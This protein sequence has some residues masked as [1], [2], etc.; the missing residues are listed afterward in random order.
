MMTSAQLDTPVCWPRVSA[1]QL[2]VFLSETERAGL[3]ACDIFQ[4]LELGHAEA[5]YKSGIG[6]ISLSDFFRIEG[7]IAR[8]LDDLTA[9]LSE[10]KLSFETGAFVTSQINRAATLNE[11][12]HSLATYFNMMHA[13]HYNVVRETDRTVTLII[14]D[15]TFPYTLRDD[16]EMVH[17]IG[18]CVL[19]KVQCLL[20]SLS[21]GLAQ[22]ALKR[23]S[24]KRRHRVPSDTTVSADHLCFW[25]APLSYRNDNY[26]L[27]FDRADAERTM[28][29]HNRV[30]LSAEGVFSR[31]VSYLEHRSPCSE[32]SCRIRVLELV[33]QGVYHQES[34]AEFLNMSVATLRRRLDA[35]GTSFREIVTAY[36]MEQATALLKK[37]YT[38]VRVT[39][40]LEY[41]DIRAFNRAFKRWTG[42]TPAAF[43]KR[44]ASVVAAQ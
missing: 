7:E 42:E 26:E 18:E 39:E 14:N 23:V 10:R 35:D 22:K 36:R 6:A 4:A 37:G 3:P 13:E 19:I 8:R 21:G 44:N 12:I 40:Q 30:D 1:R 31:V 11:A 29:K 32:T 2:K 24:L 27:V 43:A 41:S 25:T 38:V 9:H 20:D 5:V 16:P 17:F 28:H 34:V 33:R 15:S